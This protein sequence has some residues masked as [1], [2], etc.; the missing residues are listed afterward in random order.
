VS[1]NP[2][3]PGAGVALCRLDDLADPGAK[4][5]VFR[6]DAAMFSGF[7]VRLGNGVKGYVDSCPHAG[8]RLAGISDNF[9]STVLTDGL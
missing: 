1:S 4:G 9:L 2:A 6:E 8:W 7:V 3:R 5:F